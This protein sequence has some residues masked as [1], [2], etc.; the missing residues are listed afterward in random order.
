MK[1]YSVLLAISLSFLCSN[2]QAQVQVLEEEIE[3]SV[4][5]TVQNDTLPMDGKTLGVDDYKGEPWRIFPNPALDK[6]VIEEP[7]EWSE[8]NY[9]FINL[10]GKTVKRGFLTGQEINVNELESGLY[11]VLITNRKGLVL[12]KKI[13]KQ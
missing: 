12:Q 10:Q 4:T 3:I 8:A 2:I 5:D 9:K 11:I 13:I 6:I 1:N 7:L